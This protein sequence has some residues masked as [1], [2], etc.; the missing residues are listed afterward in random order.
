FSTAAFVLGTPGHS[1]QTVAC[2]GMSIGHKSLIF[3]AKTLAGSA[4]DLIE[5][6]G[7]IEKAEEERKGRLKGQ[8]YRSPIPDELGPALRA[9]REAAERLGG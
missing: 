2:S 5:D 9:A 7:L 8:T 1:W 4:L 6:P 3:A